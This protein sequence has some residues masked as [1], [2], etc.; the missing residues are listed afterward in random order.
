[1]TLNYKPQQGRILYGSTP[2]DEYE[3]ESWRDRIAMVPQDPALF[4]TTILENIRY[5]KPDAT[6]S[7]VRAVAKLANCQGFI[8]ALPEG[9]VRAATLQPV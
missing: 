6:M 7:E 9:Y 8:D 2:I 4:S 1:M 5:G 3:V